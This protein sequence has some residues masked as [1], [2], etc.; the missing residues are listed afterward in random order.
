METQAQS[1]S[2]RFGQP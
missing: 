1:R 2:Q